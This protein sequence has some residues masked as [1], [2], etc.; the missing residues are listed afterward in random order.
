VL[1]EFQT[2]SK[3]SP[4]FIHL[5]LGPACVGNWLLPSFAGPPAM[6]SA[7]GKEGRG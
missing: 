1:A 2:P 7:G 6:S 4:A 3:S 5:P